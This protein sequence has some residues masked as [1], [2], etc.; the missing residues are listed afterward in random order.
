VGR[1][2]PEAIIVG[3]H[4]GTVASELSRPFRSAASNPNLFEPEESAAH[5]M[6][7]LNGLSPPDSGRVFAWDGQ[8]IPF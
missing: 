4:P 3:L 6:S 1:T 8:A 7:V 5:L 2:R